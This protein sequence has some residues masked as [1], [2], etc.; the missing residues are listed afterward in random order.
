MWEQIFPCHLQ[1]DKDDVKCEHE[2]L[3]KVSSVMCGAV[4]EVFIFKNIFILI[5]FSVGHKYSAFVD[6]LADI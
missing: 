4:H 3:I 5:P 2:K 6:A 1:L